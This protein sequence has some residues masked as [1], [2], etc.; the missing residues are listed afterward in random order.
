MVHKLSKITLAILSASALSFAS[1]VHAQEAPAAA[2]KDVEVIEI[3]GIRSALSSALFEKR[4]SSNLIEVINAED[5]GKLPDQNLAEVLENV[6][7]I[8]ITRTA[9]VGTGVQIRGTN[10]NRVE[11]NGVSTVGSG[12]GRNGIDFEDVSA[13]IISAVEITKS[14]EAKTTE[15]SVG[16]TVNL[17]TIRPLELSETL[18]SVRIQGE[19]SSLSVEGILPRV[20]AAY[21]DNWEADAGRFGFVISGSY[22]EQEAVS[23]RPRVDRDNLGTNSSGGEPSEFLGIQFLTQEQENDD[24]ETTNIATT[25]EF[26]PNDNMKFHF[27]AI[28]TSQ[29]QSRD[30]Y[31]LQASGFGRK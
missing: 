1:N 9:G 2:N 29:E 16:G 19:D 10:S 12:G 26:A 18:G 6:T 3:T 20:S 7:G 11:I 15:G 25:F 24:Y 28:I 22:I 17:R 4:E 30:Q 8:Q 23:F 14:P 13:A 21:G 27:D 5:I 31:R